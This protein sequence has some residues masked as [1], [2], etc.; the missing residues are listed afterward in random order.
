MNKLHNKLYKVNKI[1]FLLNNKMSWLLIKK[2]KQQNFQYKI[3]KFK[4]KGNF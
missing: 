4:K 2:T 1:L 3:N